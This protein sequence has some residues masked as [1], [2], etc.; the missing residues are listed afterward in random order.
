[1]QALLSYHPEQNSSLQRGKITTSLQN[2]PNTEE[3][4]L[5]ECRSRLAREHWRRIDHYTGVPGQPS[6]GLYFE[7]WERKIRSQH[8]VVFAFRGTNLKEWADWRSNLRWFRFLRRTHQKDDQYDVARREVLKIHKRLRAQPGGDKIKFST[9]GHSLGGGL[10][11]HAFYACL[12]QMNRTVVF[13]TSPV[14]GFMDLPKAQRLKFHQMTYRETFPYYRVLRV[15]E[16]G[17][18]LEY[19]RRFTQTFYREDSMIRA[20]EVE[21]EHGGSS[22]NKHSMARLTRGILMQG[23]IADQRLEKLNQEIKSASLL[24]DL[25]APESAGVV[26]D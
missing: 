12:P 15:H 25:N 11:Q 20:V 4:L 17:E 13:D 18:I 5:E 6:E 22:I 23:L 26:V 10:A 3:G 7:V 24:H 19:I 8:E 9:T 2:L 14:T 16:N 21:V 1:M